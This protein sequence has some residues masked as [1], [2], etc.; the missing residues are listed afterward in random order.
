VLAVM[1]KNLKKA[2]KA[3]GIKAVTCHTARHTFA[4]LADEAGY[5]IT[6]LQSALN[7][8][9]P[10]ITSKYIGRLRGDRMAG[11]RKELHKLL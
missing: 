3:A 11:K 8:S 7:H 5:T 10:E 4:Y 9:K 2:C 6:E 1:N